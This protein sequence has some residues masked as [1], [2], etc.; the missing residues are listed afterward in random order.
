MARVTGVENLTR[1]LRAKAME[2]KRAADEAAVIVGYSTSYA[3]YVHEDMEAKHPIGQAKF[4]EQPAR[5]CQE[6]MRA[7]IATAVQS[8]KTLL[9]ALLMAGLYLQAQSQVLCP[10]D[11]GTLHNSAFTRKEE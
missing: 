5:T 9:Q 11:T 8:G 4:L 7:I 6:Q 1:E 3:I 2:L 10:V